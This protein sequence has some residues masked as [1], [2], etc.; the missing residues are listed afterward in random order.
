[1]GTVRNTV[2]LAALDGKWQKKKQENP[3]RKTENIVCGQ[4]AAM[5]EQKFDAEVYVADSSVD[6]VQIVAGE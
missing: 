3:V 6:S 4:L 5:L 1:M 2:S